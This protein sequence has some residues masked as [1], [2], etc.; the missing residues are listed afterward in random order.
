MPSNGR[1]AAVALLASVVMAAPAHAVTSKSWTNICGGNLPVL[2]TCASITLDVIGTQ[3]TLRIKNLTGT[4]GSYENFVFTSIDL[5]NVPVAV[6]ALNDKQ[7]VTHMEGPYRTS[8]PTNPPP[9]WTVF[10]YK[11]D[12]KGVLGLDF[13]TGINGNDG[14]IAS[15]CGTSLPGGSNRLWMTE[16]CGTGNATDP[17]LLTDPDYGWV[18]IQ[19]NVNSTWDVAGTELQIHGQSNTG[20]IKCTTGEDC[21]PV[22]PEPATMALMAT[23]LAGLLAARRRRRQAET[24]DDDTAAA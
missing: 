13:G 4:Y 19:F 23:G 2:T 6:D 10:N 1:T 8:N 7:P 12:G 11:G 20:S 9:W 22:T 15:D 5:Y 14:G 3:V 21:M 24:E 18:V 17:R 16:A